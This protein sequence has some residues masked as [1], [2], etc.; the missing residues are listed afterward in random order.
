MLQA[1]EEIALLQAMNTLYPQCE[2]KLAAG[3]YTGQLRLVASL[4]Q[5][6][7]AFFQNVMVMADDPVLRQQ[8]L[9]LL[10]GLQWHMSQVADLSRLAA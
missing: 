6:V 3:D 2:A 7:D 5:A 9:A 10:S 4:H 8:R 1:P